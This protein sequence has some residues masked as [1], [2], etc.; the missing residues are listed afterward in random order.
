MNSKPQQTLWTLLPLLLGAGLVLLQGGGLD[1]PVSLA[2]AAVFLLLAFGKPSADHLRRRLSPTALAVGVW[3]LLSLISGLTTKWGWLAAEEAA[4]YLTAFCVFCILLLRLKE[5]DG[6]EKLCM[7]VAVLCALCALLSVDASSA[8]L[9]STPVMALVDHLGGEYALMATGYEPGVRITG[10][11]G[12]PNALAGLLA[13][14]VFLSFFLLQTARTSKARLAAA[15]LTMTNAFGF[16]LA[17]SMGG[18]A[19][20]ALAVG[21]YLLLAH[22]DRRLA[23]LVTLTETTVLA[24]LLAFTA[25]P[26]LGRSGPAGLWPVLAGPMGGLPLWAIQTKLQPGKGTKAAEVTAGV[27]AAAVAYVILGYNLTGGTALAPGQTLR[28]SV[29]P[30]GGDYQ[31]AAQWDGA[32]V[33]VTVESQNT[34]QTI[35]HTSTVLYRGG[36]DQAA[37]TVPQDSRVVHITLSAPQGAR[38]EDMTLSGGKKV[39]LGYKLFPGFVANRIQ[40]LWANQNAI[41]RLEFF[42]D[43]L[44]MFAASPLVGSGLGCVEEL[45]TQVQR[46]YYESRYVHNHY[47]QVMAE[48]GLPGLLAFLAVL[49]AAGYALLRRRREGDKSP[50][51]AALGAC[52]AMMALHAGVEAVWSFG[53]YQTAALALLAG[54]TVSFDRPVKTLTEK[55]ALLSLCRGTLCLA[56]LCGGLLMAGHLSAAKEYA[57]IQA[58]RKPQYA[59][60]MDKLAGRD[61]Y[62]WAQYKLD[63]ALNAAVVDGPYG[64]LAGE[65][66]AQLRRLGDYAINCQ[67]MASHYFPRGE[68]EEFF[69]ASREGLRQKASSSAAWQEQFDLYEAAF[70]SGVLDDPTWFAGQCLETYDQL[71]AFNQG[72]MGPVSLSAENEAFL[73]L[74][75]SLA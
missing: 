70:H 72:R 57:D 10:I 19:A 59:N 20:F 44:K 42:R 43:G 31:L 61:R 24:L 23:L 56:A 22:P 37:F 1:E 15:M 27:L 65:Y 62:N 41:Q 67:L 35:M 18:I 28:R 7:T 58:G 16:L 71:L 45:V 11:F 53:F 69:A 3:F 5:Q 54:I 49:G 60:T 14:G 39:P 17:F 6:V 13:F 30:A 64:R 46:F 4:K 38:L 9:F 33:S 8:G 55:K 21:A 75:R 48:M 12:N 50:L 32:P 29:Y 74:L 66:A 26:F 51:L 25:M 2:A 52:L 63:L 68:L 47:I 34:Q 73:Q 40:G 36:L